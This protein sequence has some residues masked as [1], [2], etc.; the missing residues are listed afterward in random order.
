MK[1][2]S[3]Y[4]TCFALLIIAIISMVFKIS[5]VQKIYDN[6]LPGAVYH[7]NYH[8][9]LKE[10]NQKAIISA[11][12]P[13]D[14]EHQ[15]I[16]NLEYD[17]PELKFKQK[18]IEENS[19]AVW[20]SRRSNKFYTISHSYLFKGKAIQFELSDNLKI[21]QRVYGINKRFL[22]SEQHIQVHHN[23]INAL[24]RVLRENKTN[25][26]DVISSLFD[27]VVNIPKAPM[28]DRASAITILDQNYGSPL[29]KSRLFVALC[30]NSGIPSRLKTGL[31]LDENLKNKEHYWTEVLVKNQWVP[32]DTFY[33]HYA[34]LP[35]NYLELGTGY[36]KIIHPNNGTKTNYD[37]TIKRINHI[38][39]VNNNAH[40]ITKANKI[41]LL[42]LYERN[43]IPEYFLFFLLLFP[44]GALLVT[45]LKNIVGFHTYTIFTVLLG[46]FYLSITGWIYGIIG[47]L[48]IAIVLS[49]I[50]YT[51]RYW[52]LLHTPNIAL[53][54]SC[55]SIVIVAMLMIGAWFDYS[56]IAPFIQNS[57]PIILFLIIANNCSR[58]ISSKGTV[59]TIQ[60]FVFFMISS[61]LCYLI[62]SSELIKSLVLIFPE[63]ILISLVFLLLLGKWIGLKLSEYIQYYKILK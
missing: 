58:D 44:I 57:V 12:L 16:S 35:A 39:Y 46:G 28:E 17:A 5:L 2:T 60:K 6:F 38:P 18:L 62:F 52:K 4:I 45:F 33:S 14:N 21:A 36:L 1:F 11:Y 25:L 13:Q 3:Y 32:F 7:V 27:Y 31:I 20:S 29:S 51:L 37:I 59:I 24:A 22:S 55:S 50:I 26:K 15:K 63:I 19:T 42:P 10:G 40:E 30:R 54:T 56:L 41:S 49:G 61:S 23:S 43:I 48:F 34:Y 8:I 47:L 9:A 53:I